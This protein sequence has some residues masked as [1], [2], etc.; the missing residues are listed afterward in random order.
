VG[1][2]SGLLARFKHHVKQGVI[3]SGFDTNIF[4]GKECMA[5]GENPRQNPFP[6]KKKS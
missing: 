4:L 6:K 3:L 5:G 2:F 1:N